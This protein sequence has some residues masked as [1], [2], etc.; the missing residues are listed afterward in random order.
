[1]TNFW[2]FIHLL[3]LVRACEQV[4]RLKICIFICFLC[5]ARIKTTATF[6]HTRAYLTNQRHKA[7]KHEGALHRLEADRPVLALVVVETHVSACAVR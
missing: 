2:Q 6:S 7:R 3:P 4:F 1:M 5:L